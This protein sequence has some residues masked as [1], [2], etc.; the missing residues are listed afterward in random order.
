MDSRLLS[1][2][3]NAVYTHDEVLKLSAVVSREGS[4]NMQADNRWFTNYSAGIEYDFKRMIEGNTTLSSFSTNLSYAHMGKLLSDDRFNSG[5]SYRV[6]LGFT[7]EP[8]LGSYSGI[9]GLTRPYS[10][11]WVGYGIPWAYTN[12]VNLGVRVG[13]LE[14]R[15]RF[16]I[17]G[18][19]KADKD[20]LLPVP[21]AAEW[22]YTGAYK[23]GLEVNN[24]GVDFSLAAQ[25][26]P[27][28]RRK[29][30][31]LFT[32]N[33]NYNK[34]KLVA[35]PDGLT[36]VQIGNTNLEVGKPID[37][38]WVLKNNGVY[39][40]DGEVTINPATSKPVT[41]KGVPLKAGDPRWEDINGDYIINDDDKV[42]EGNYMPRMS[43]G[44]GSSLNYEGFSLDFQFYFALKR[45]ALNQY[46]SSRLDFINTEVNNNI[47]SVKEITFWERKQDL[48]TYPVYNPW[49]PVVPYRLEQDLFLDNASYLKLR[50]VSLAYDLSRGGTKT[51]FRNCTL[52]VTG[53]NLLTISPFKGD[54]PELVNYN[55]IYNGYG[56]LNPKSL[57]LGVRIGF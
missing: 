30:S 35:L 53:T 49:S 31:W 48:S 22:G 28:S 57:I 6:D 36:N 14:D 10:S 34:N 18:Y 27:V 32:A 17:D 3:G 40:S 46:A 41:Y 50:S 38:F 5:P 51:V 55:G 2:F 23:N 21:V 43:G 12:Q 33:F 26:L 19:R 24:T 37:A 1:F 15:L 13:L 16:G 47:N 11:G 25:I 4:S 39:N 20:M 44:F 8:T 54:D 7:D 29:L 56:L 52:Y 45:N 9:G 42:L